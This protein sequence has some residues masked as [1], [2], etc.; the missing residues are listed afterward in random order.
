MIEDPAVRGEGQAVGTADTR[1][2]LNK[3]ISVQP[4]QSGSTR[5]QIVRAYPMIDPADPH[6]PLPINGGFVQR[7]LRHGRRRAQGPCAA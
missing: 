2:D 3:R 6:P 4:E 5:V 1:I 7:G